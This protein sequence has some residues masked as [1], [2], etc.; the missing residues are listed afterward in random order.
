[1]VEKVRGKLFVTLLLAFLLCAEFRRSAQ[2]SGAAAEEGGAA[3]APVIEI[4]G[5]AVRYPDE[6]ETVYVGTG[7]RFSAKLTGVEDVNA[8]EDLG[9]LV[10]IEGMP[11]IENTPTEGVG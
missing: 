1:M 8:I 10:N 2:P 11:T 9:V 4:E 6:D 7:L 5:A 3:A